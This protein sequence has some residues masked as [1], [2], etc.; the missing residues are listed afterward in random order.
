M[1]SLNGT[2]NGINGINGTNGANGTNGTKGTNGAN[3]HTPDLQEIHDFLI[4]LS[5]KAGEMIMN[6][7]PLV[8]GV[9]SKKNS[10]IPL[11][12]TKWVETNGKLKVLIWSP[13]LI[14]RW[15]R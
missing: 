10:K 1:V 3:G 11:L 8:N 6:A 12:P 15:K 13:R 5:S 9:G 4:E 2:S 7:H 14:R